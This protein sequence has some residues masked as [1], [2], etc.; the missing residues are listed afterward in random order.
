MSAFGSVAPDRPPTSLPFRESLALLILTAAVLLCYSNT[1]TNPFIFDDIPNILENKHIR[2]DRINFDTLLEA[3]FGSPSQRRPLSNLSF[4]LN[5]YFSGYWVQAYRIVN[6]LI[7]IVTGILLY[8]VIKSALQASWNRAGKW[9][10]APVNPTSG[11]QDGKTLGRTPILPFMTA[12]VWVVHPLQIQSVTYL[13]QRMNALA[14]MFFLLA[15]FLFI[16]AD[17]VRQTHKK[18]MLYALCGIS[19]VAALASKEIAA[20]LP[21]CL[22]LYRWFFVLDLKWQHIKRELL[23]L[24]LVFAILVVLTI[25]F[26]GSH[27]WEAIQAGYSTRQFTMPQRVLTEFRV[28]VFYVSLFLFP[29]PSRLNLDHHFLVSKSLTEPITTILALTL[30]IGTVVFTAGL[31]RKF[32]VVSFCILWYL[33]NLL[34]ESSVIGLEI[35]FEHRN[36]L[37]SMSLAFLL[38][39][40]LCTRF[41]S[42]RVLLILL[43]GI[44]TVFSL[45][46][47]QR[48][49]IWWDD[50]TLWRDCAQKSQAK[51]RP[52]NKLGAALERRGRLQEALHCYMRANQVDPMA[53]LPYYNKGNV[54]TKIGRNEEAIV[55][56]HRALHLYPGFTKARINLALALANQG[57]LEAGIAQLEKA[58]AES[59]SDPVALNN[60]GTLLFKAGQLEAAVGHFL[61]AITQAPSNATLRYAAGNAL[62][63]L[64]R[65]DE[66][67]VQYREAL[68]ID[69]SNAMVHNNLAI[70]LHKNGEIEA[71]IK[72]FEAARKLNP[73][74]VSIQHNL[75]KARAEKKN[76][77]H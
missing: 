27:P 71:A 18:V 15:F 14:A 13:V 57:Q 67:I 5:Y 16:T 60:M 48:N 6:I 75:D 8:Y 9:R 31:S 28:I 62:S 17:T 38:V 73:D 65:L 77:R 43:C 63:A 29:H 76:A 12:F 69:P 4:A 10:V 40:H 61:R 52:V 25:F 44:V 49:R 70:T 58:I 33:G 59:P 46:T 22:L 2:L 74:D 53:L 41:K 72:V 30:I 64:D 39:W 11:C 35:I 34:L 32:R 51:A 36:Y 19:G 24:I 55:E 20:T 37:P 26:L 21:F 7:H 68:R 3:A 47:Y 56:Y 23:A 54:L 50:L 45:W 1:L 42:R 66:A